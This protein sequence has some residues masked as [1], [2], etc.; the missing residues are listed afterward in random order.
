MII[1]PELPYI[2]ADDF[3]R[4]FSLRAQNLMWLLG[5]GASASAGVPTAA[6]RRAYLDGKLAGAKPSYGHIALATLIK[7]NW[8]RIVWTTNFAELVAAVFGSTGNLTTADWDSSTRALQATQEKWWPVE[9]KLHGEFRSRRLKNTREELR[10]QDSVMRQ[11][12]V[13]ASRQNGLVMVGCSG[14]RTY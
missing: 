8:T 10:R 4:R 13:H 1:G 7:T 12:L 5:A 11:A 3:A 6:D 9:V 14:L 2:G